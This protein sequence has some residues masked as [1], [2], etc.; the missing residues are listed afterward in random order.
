VIYHY[1]F[2]MRVNIN[3]ELLARLKMEVSKDPTLASLSVLD[4]LAPEYFDDVVN[5]LKS[6]SIGC[7]DK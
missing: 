6:I 4:L 7:G 1:C 3:V 2:Q 5:A